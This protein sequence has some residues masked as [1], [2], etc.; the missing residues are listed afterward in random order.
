MF[1]QM[2]QKVASRYHIAVSQYD[3]DVRAKTQAVANA[4]K[5]FKG[6]YEHFSP[7]AASV[8]ES[9]PISEGDSPKEVL[10]VMNRRGKMFVATA[11]NDTTLKK[12]L[13][14][15]LGTIKDDP[16]N[17]SRHAS[18]VYWLRDAHL[19]AGFSLKD[20][21][22]KIKGFV[23]TYG[24]ENVEMA[25]SQSNIREVLP[26]KI[27][28]FLPKNIVIETDPN[29]VISKMTDRF[30]NQN[31]NLESKIDSLKLL[32]QNYNEIVKRVKGDL[33]SDNED[34]HLGA[35]ITWIMLETGIRPGSPGNKVVKVVNGENV[36][37][38]T[39]GASGLLLK[40][41]NYVSE[42]FV[43]LQF[44]GK[45]LK[46]NVVGL[47]DRAAIK[48]LM[49]Y[50]DRALSESEEE[51][52][53]DESANIPVF[54]KDNGMQFS[55]DALRK[56]FR[57]R[58]S[59]KLTPKNLRQLKATSEILENLYEEQKNLYA[60]IRK[61]VKEEVKDLKTRITEEVTKTIELAVGNAQRALHH[62]T[63]RI[64][65]DYYASPQVVL[66]FLSSGKVD[67]SLHKVVLENKP[68]LRFDPNL[69]L[70]QALKK[71]ARLLTFGYTQSKRA[72]TL[73]DV[74]GD[75]EDSMKSNGVRL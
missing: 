22:E 42:D 48:V 53:L 17:K 3:Q 11:K 75:L 2:T 37:I 1:R 33:A 39:F 59:S 16:K 5:E 51:I 50:A 9:L 14:T 15:Y 55:P 36:E 40:H 43:I 52:V 72:T 27:R 46:E 63:S 71:T 47:K 66:N 18:V 21:L 62:D 41:I 12:F 44:P 26:D 57:M 20:G 29:G 31:D 38:E 28:D 69:F 60:T 49:D 23:N 61:F 67:N 4:A 35:L 24:F 45:K 68:H 30:S 65:V 56:Y 25:V 54:R 74:L 32:V 58:V 7:L 34:L 73:L 8:V 10:E 64:T 6:L 19:K 70:E 13:D